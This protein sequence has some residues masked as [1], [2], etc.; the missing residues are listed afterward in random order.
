M[1]MHNGNLGGWNYIKRPLSESLN[2]KWYLGV[3][4]GTDSE[5]AFALFL[6]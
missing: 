6:D 4:G 2:D 1:W 3:K 5:W